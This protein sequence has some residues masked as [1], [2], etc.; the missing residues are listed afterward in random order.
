MWHPA[1]KISELAVGEAVAVSVAGESIAIYHLASGVYA[2]HD[3]CT[4]A[5]A[6]L[7]EGYV[8]GDC[9]E[10]PLHEGVFHI[11]TG[12]PMSGPVCVPVRIFPV[13]IEGDD[14]SIEL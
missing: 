1:A 9:V 3:R 10:C 7:A 5:Q 2:T 14:I 8:D 11:P 6:S 4:H 13:R 12:K